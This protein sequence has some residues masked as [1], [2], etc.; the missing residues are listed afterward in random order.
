MRGAIIRFRPSQV[1]LA[2]EPVDAGLN[3]K[4]TAKRRNTFAGPP[5]LR[6]GA[7]DA[8][9]SSDRPERPRTSHALL[10]SNYLKQRE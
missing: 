10:F 3:L 2:P 6:A 5:E 9:V 7:T 4:R 1:I 8:H